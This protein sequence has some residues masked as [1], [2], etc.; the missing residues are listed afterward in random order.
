M[1]VDADLCIKLGGSDTYRYLYD[2]LPLVAEELYIHNIVYSEIRFP[3]SAQNQIEDL[4]REKKMKRID[5]TFL[6]KSERLIYA[7]T[8]DLL[9]SVMI[10]PN[11]PNIN[12]GE[13]ALASTT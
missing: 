9:A 13:V 7:A 2:I 5:E 6:C 8:F 3:S 4:I 12:K 10:N 11:L 1:I